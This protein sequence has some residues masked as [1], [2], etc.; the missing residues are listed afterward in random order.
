[1][2][3]NVKSNLQLWEVYI[4]ATFL[5]SYFFLL[6]PPLFFPPFIVVFKLKDITIEGN[7][8]LKCLQ[9]IVVLQIRNRAE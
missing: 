7:S 9:L 8:Y 6:P 4:N 2:L 1:M 5:H 3:Q